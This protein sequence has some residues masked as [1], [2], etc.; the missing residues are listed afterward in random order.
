MLV[1]PDKFHAK[2]AKNTEML[3]TYPEN[4]LKMENQ[5][6]KYIKSVK[7]LRI[8]IDNR[9]HFDTPYFLSTQKSRQSIKYF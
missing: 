8:N 5:R 9:L 7:I 4:T 2:V 3:D 6:Y 1:K